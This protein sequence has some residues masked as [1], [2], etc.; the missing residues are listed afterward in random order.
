VINMCPRRTLCIPK[1]THTLLLVLY[2]ISGDITGAL[3]SAVLVAFA[4]HALVHFAVQQDD[5]KACEM[6]EE[7]DCELFSP[8]QERE[9]RLVG[10]ICCRVPRDAPQ[11]GQPNKDCAVSAG[12]GCSLCCSVHGY[13]LQDGY[14]PALCP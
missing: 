5:R 11:T 8:P 2:F 4:P 1:A 10:L 9:L 14:A 7:I 12:V 13:N 6:R 3:Y